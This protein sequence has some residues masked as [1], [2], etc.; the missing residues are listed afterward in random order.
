MVFIHS[1]N[2]LHDTQECVPI[3]ENG[4][5]ADRLDEI[6]TLL[7]EQRADEFRVRSYRRAA[8]T[9]R[10]LK[11]PLQEILGR[12]GVEGLIALPTIGASIANLIEQQLRLGRMPLLD[13]LRGEVSAE[14]FF[15]TLPGIGPKL[16]HKLHDFLH[17]ETLPELYIAAREG[18]LDQVPGIGHKRAIAIRETLAQ[19]IKKTSEANPAF[20]Q[21]NCS[22]PVDD[23]LAIDKE[24]R[25]QASEDRLPKIAPRK[26]NPGNVAW[27][28]ILHTELNGGHYTALFSN[29][30][31]A[32]DLNTTSDWVVIY[33]DDLG[34]NGRW[35][36]ITSQFGDLLGYRIVRGR[37]DECR[38]YYKRLQPVEQAGT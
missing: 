17:V 15:T 29:S 10:Q 22:V 21:M 3:A 38:A 5:V 31:R 14:H 13:R 33:C 11:E 26:F 6:A 25:R 23:I 1:N 7:T 30:A 35:T 27:L 4:M 9:V 8:D 28:P 36:V 34:I 32:H 24:Y 2:L 12:G 37:E 19:R 18:R 20:I 16:S